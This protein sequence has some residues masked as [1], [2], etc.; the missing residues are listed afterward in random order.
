[1]SDALFRLDGKT[2]VVTGAGSGIG[3]AISLLY[4]ERGARVV[5]LDV[6]LAAAQ[7]VAEAIAKA[8]GDGWALDCDVSDEASVARAFGAILGRRPH[9]AILVNNAGVA[10]VGDALTT[11][12]AD[13]ERLFRVNVLGV[14]HCTRAALPSMIAHGGGSIVNLASIASFIAIKDRWAYSMTK[15]A[16]LSMTRSIALDF[17]ERKVRCNC[18]APARVHTPFVDGFVARNYPGKEDEVKASLH[19]YQPVGRMGTPREVAQLCLYLAS[20]EASFVTGAAYPIDGG[21]MMQ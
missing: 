16:V 21:V 7:R 11:D 2:A 12:S 8:G 14:H 5:L 10:H 1:M 20:D 13:F 19:K 17:V 15:G 9:I 18:V 6:D 4:A 3:E